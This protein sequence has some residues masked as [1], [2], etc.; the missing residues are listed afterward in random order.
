MS[1]LKGAPVGG[2]GSPVL[3]TGEGEECIDGVGSLATVKAGSVVSMAA[4]AS[5]IAGEA[6]GKGSVSVVVGLTASI[7]RSKDKEG[8]GVIKVP[9]CCS[10][11]STVRAV[12]KTP[13]GGAWLGGLGESAWEELDRPLNGSIWWCAMC[14]DDEQECDDD[15]KKCK[16]HKT[17]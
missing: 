1:P 16:E 3:D 6:G 15:G 7:A 4:M 9:A 14:Y 11:C 2:S 8:S 10:S 12:V 5:A 13:G 17:A